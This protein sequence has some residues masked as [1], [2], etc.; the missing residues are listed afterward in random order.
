[1]GMLQTKATG[2]APPP[3]DGNGGGEAMNERASALLSAWIAKLRRFSTEPNL[4]GYFDFDGPAADT[5]VAEMV[6]TAGRCRLQGS[7]GEALG[8][9]KGGLRFDQSADR[10]AVAVSQVVNE[11]T[12]FLGMNHGGDLA[13]DRPALGEG[14]LAFQPT[15]PPE[16]GF[17]IG[18]EPEPFGPLFVLSWVTVLADAVQRNVFNASGAEHADQKKQ[19]DALGAVLALL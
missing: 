15:P 16:P 17:E 4:Y 10:W 19:N 1:M 5:L 2:A 14:L 11:H 18:E 13:P 7:I 12:N 9:I 6:A 3:S 8:R